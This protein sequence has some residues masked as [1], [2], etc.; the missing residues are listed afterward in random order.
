MNEAVTVVPGMVG[1]VM[2]MGSDDNI[3]GGGGDDGDGGDQLG[4]VTYCWR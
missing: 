1:L 2:L 3:E 4:T